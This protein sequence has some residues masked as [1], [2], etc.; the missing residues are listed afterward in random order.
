MPSTFPPHG[1]GDV[2]VAAVVNFVVGKPRVERGERRPD[3]EQFFGIN[4]V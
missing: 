4:V 2:V 1:Y 3:G